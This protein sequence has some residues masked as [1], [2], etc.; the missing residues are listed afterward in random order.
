MRKIQIALLILVLAAFLV[1]M[2]A[3]AWT[4]EPRASSTTPQE[5]TP[6]EGYRVFQSMQLDLKSD[7]LDGS[8]QLLQDERVVGPIRDELW[9]SDCHMWCFDGTDLREFCASIG[10]KPLLPAMVCLVRTDGSVADS[11]TME[12]ELASLTVHHLYDSRRPTYFVT[13]DYSVGAGAYNGPSTFLA[14]VKEGKLQWLEVYNP[15]TG[16]KQE[17]VLKKALKRAWKLLPRALGPGQQ[18]VTVEGWPKFTEDTGG[19]PLNFERI[20]TRFHFDGLRWLRFER[21]EAG[22]FFDE[23]DF[24]NADEFPSPDKTP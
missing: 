2:H 13:A 9:G 7:G 5:A 17:I 16:Q 24:P 18:I 19:A 1:A 11:R 4:D 3:A 10:K 23:G 12:R 22:D 14:E 6:P 8:L 21:R 15:K 20:Y